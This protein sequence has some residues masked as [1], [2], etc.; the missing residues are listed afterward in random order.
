MYLFFLLSSYL[1]LHI[2]LFYLIIDLFNTPTQCFHLTTVPWRYHYLYVCVVKL[3]V[4]WKV[5]P[6]FLFNYMYM[7]W[8]F[9]FNTRAVL[10]FW[11]GQNT[12]EQLIM[13]GKEFNCL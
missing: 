12:S 4:S 9:L 8:S 10:T 1:Y 11:S 13:V 3:A 6:S 2:L 5:K 7:L